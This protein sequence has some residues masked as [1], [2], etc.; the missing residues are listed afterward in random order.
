MNEYAACS[1]HSC[2]ELFE[3]IIIIVYKTVTVLNIEIALMVCNRIPDTG[4]E[5]SRPD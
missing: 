4:L 3:S 5:I 2:N 1:P